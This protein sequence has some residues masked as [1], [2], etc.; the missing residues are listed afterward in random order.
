MDLSVHKAIT[1]IALLRAAKRL[2]TD[3]SPHFNGLW[4][5][6]WL[7]DLNQV[8]AFLDMVEKRVDPYAV[9]D[10]SQ[11]TYI[12]PA[13]VNKR[14]KEWT[15]LYNAL[16]DVE[17]EDTYAAYK[18]FFN[19][20]EV[21]TTRNLQVSEIEGQPVKLDYLIKPVDPDLLL[22]RMHTILA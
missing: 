7:T 15:N 12:P 21:P 22:D 10:E 6:N 14:P 5:G 9:F 13:F 8:T 2:K 20:S 16:W 18:G 17:W 1:A 11:G 4:V 3:L 19:L